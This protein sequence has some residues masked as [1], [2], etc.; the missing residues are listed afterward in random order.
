MTKRPFRCVMMVSRK[1]SAWSLSAKSRSNVRR[2][3]ARLAALSWRMRRRRGDA[4]SAISPWSEKT[5][6]ISAMRAPSGWMSRVI[7]RSAGYISSRGGAKNCAIFSYVSRDAAKSENSC[8][9]STTSFSAFSSTSR[10][11]CVSPSGVVISACKTPTASSVSDK[12]RATTSGYTD[13]RHESARSFASA[14]TAKS[15]KRFRISVNSS[16]CK[17]SEFIREPL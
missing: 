1:K 3:C 14:E 10:R 7:S 6:R 17:I 13:G 9:M 2:I 5:R 8:G 16:I 11:S 12:S 15:A 4:L